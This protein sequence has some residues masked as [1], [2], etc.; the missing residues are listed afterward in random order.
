MP[1]ARSREGRVYCCACQA[2]IVPAAEASEP[3]PESTAGR[4]SPLAASAP[5]SSADP[6]T[7]V[8]VRGGSSG[9]GLSNTGGELSV[10]NA[11]DKVLQG[12][13]RTNRTCATCA[14][15]LLRSPTGALLCVQCAS[16]PPTAAPASNVAS[17]APPLPAPQ[18]RAQ[19]PAP[20][21]D[22]H[23]PLLLTAPDAAA[24]GAN[25]DSTYAELCAAEQAVVAALRT[26]RAGLPMRR[27]VDGIASIV[28]AI[29]DAAATIEQLR[30]ARSSVLGGL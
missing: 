23:S 22:A 13:T 24:M 4:T 26:L 28:R 18:A 10:P 14:T 1:L 3:E 8:A 12:W 20:R 29:R 17:Q 16:S 15:P 5:S 19:L 25:T 27:D 7:V 21:P 2:N 9:A 11:G 30:R 6:G